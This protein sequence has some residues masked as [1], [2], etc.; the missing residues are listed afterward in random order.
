M[1]LQIWVP[2][3]ML[4]AAIVAFCVA[5]PDCSFSCPAPLAPPGAG[6]VAS[7]WER[8][9]R[10]AGKAPG[11]LGTLAPKPFGTSRKAVHKSGSTGRRGPLEA[12]SLGLDGDPAG[13]GRR[14]RPDRSACVKGRRA[15]PILV[16]SHVNAAT[17]SHGACSEPAP[18]APR[19]PGREARCLAAAFRAARESRLVAERAD[20]RAPRS[21]CSCSSAA[22]S[23]RCPSE[24]SLVGAGAGL[25]RGGALRRPPALPPQR[26]LVLPRRHPARPRADLRGRRGTS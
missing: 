23:T 14:S 7:R 8:G 11:P 18:Q 4:I 9:Q 5:A 13:S 6:G 17:D 21:R 1:A 25:L 2:C 20:H 10:T 16:L 22:T 15:M 12:A 24:P 26:P 19:M 3:H